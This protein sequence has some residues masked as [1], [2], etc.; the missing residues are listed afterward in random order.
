MK[1]GELVESQNCSWRKIAIA[2]VI[3]AECPVSGAEAFGERLKV[4][5]MVV[6][7]GRDRCKPRFRAFGRNV[8]HPSAVSGAVG[9]PEL[10]GSVPCCL[11]SAHEPPS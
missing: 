9:G 3:L 4:P 5:R 1:A 10:D 2:Q 7:M 8:G 11:V 6:E